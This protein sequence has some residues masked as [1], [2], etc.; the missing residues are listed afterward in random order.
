MMAKKKTIPTGRVETAE[1]FLARG[2]KITICPPCER[3][4]PD[5]IEY[6][7]KKPARGRRKK[8]ESPKEVDF[9]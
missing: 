2:G 4:D 3:T 1:E 5:E 9:S 7:W 8:Q 6:T